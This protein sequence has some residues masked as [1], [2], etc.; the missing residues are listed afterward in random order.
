MQH[1]FTVQVMAR[2]WGQDYK[3]QRNL[4]HEQTLGGC[5]ARG[6]RGQ[7]PQLRRMLQVL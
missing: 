7:E 6:G 1:T 4:Q 5:T 3:T 2:N